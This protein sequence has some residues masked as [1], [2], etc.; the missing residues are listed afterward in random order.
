MIRFN[1]PVLAE[2]SEGR[3]EIFGIA[4]PYNVEAVVSDG[5]RVMFEPGA[6]PEGGPAPKLIESH[7]LG[8]IRGIVTARKNTDTGMEFTAKIAATAAGNDALELVKMGAIDSVSVGVTPTEWRMEG[9]LMVIEAANWQELSLVAIPAFSGAT[10]TK[11]AAQAT[12]DDNQPETVP[13][14]ETDMTNT[15]EVVEAAAP[16]T[17]PTA[18]IVYAQAKSYKLPTP[19]EYILKMREGGAEWQQY[20]ANVTAMIQAA[21]GDIGVSLADGVIPTP[22]VA[23]IYDDINPLRP[24]VSALGARGMPEAGAT[25]IRPFIKVRSSVGNQATEFTNLAT[26][27]FEV[28][29][30]VITKK[31]FGGRLI[32]S[33]QVIDFSSPSMLDAA[34]GDMAGQYALATEKEVVDRLAAGSLATTGIA[35]ETVDLTKADKVIEGLYK[36]AS[37]IGKV[38]NYLPNVMVVAPEVWATLGGLTDNQDR[39]VFPQISP[40]NGIGNLPGGVTSFN[41]NP[42]GLNLIVSNQVGAQTVGNKTAKEYIWLMNS[43]GLEVYEQFKGFLR[44]ENPGNLSVTLAVRGYFA[45]QIIDAKTIVALGPAA[46]FGGG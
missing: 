34:I 5:T 16:V 9:D 25:F 22:I 46:T 33:E 24:I 43:R 13:E 1:A 6:L 30:I 2:A 36:A 10:I 32:L 4:A 31:T 23:P 37:D 7:D 14:E 29:D 28:D 41:G 15:P 39:P 12:P 21:T 26:A 38:G 35:R 42:L 40:I 20:N 11:V 3:R 17:V 27:D 44:D 8:Q 45:A 19:G 18:P